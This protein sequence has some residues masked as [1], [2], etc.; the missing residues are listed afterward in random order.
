MNSCFVWLRVAPPLGFVLAGLM[1]SVSSHGA[2][3]PAGVVSSRAV[4]QPQINQVVALED[5]WVNRSTFRAG[6]RV[7]AG[8]A[9]LDLQGQD[10]EKRLND[11]QERIANLNLKL[12]DVRNASLVNAASVSEYARENGALKPEVS[13]RI[14][15]KDEIEILERTI[16]ELRRTMAKLESNRARINGVLPY[17]ILLLSDPPREGE[18]IKTGSALFRYQWLDRATLSIYNVKSISAAQMKLGG[19]CLPLRFVHANTDPK[20]RST[21][22]IYQAQIPPSLSSTYEGLLRQPQP[23]VDIYLTVMP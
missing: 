8:R 9:V 20:N 11:L 21:E 13:R 19:Q 15:R 6:E 2:S 4:L 22:W 5:G 16:S 7:A 23:Q 18:T 1:V 10:T 3:C 12:L 14:L 17:P